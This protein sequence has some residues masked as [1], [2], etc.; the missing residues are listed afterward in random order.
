M[1]EVNDKGVRLEGSI[2]NLMNDWMNATRVLY[3]ISAKEAGLKNASNA[4]GTALQI[5]TIDAAADLM[6]N[7]ELPDEH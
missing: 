2:K 3:S 6:K 7:G 5:A 1:I 4:F